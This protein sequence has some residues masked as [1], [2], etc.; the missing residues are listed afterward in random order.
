M[1]DPG[2]TYHNSFLIADPGGAIV[3][4]T[5]GRLGR[6]KPCARGVRSIS[7]G[8]TIPEF[9][10]AHASRV[11]GTI[12]RCDT[13]R[14]ITTHRARPDAAALMSLLRSH[15]SSSW[16]RYSPLS[17]AMGGPCVH[18]GGLLVSAQTTASLVGELR[19]DVQQ[20]W[21]T[22]TAAPCLSLFKPVTVAS[23]LPAVPAP[24]DRADETVAVVAP[25]AAAPRRDARTQPCTVAHLAERDALELEWLADPPDSAAAF[26]EHAARLERWLDAVAVAARPPPTVG[27]ALLGP[28]G[29]RC[30]PDGG[31]MPVDTRCRPAPLRLGIDLDARRH[32]G[33]GRRPAL[34]VLTWC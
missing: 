2:F 13:R 29:P 18:G 26:A 22:A 31:Y 15:G 12:S 32:R 5:A 8:L 33:S 14:S 9:A 4:E 16:P 34:G 6:A 24:T 7:N 11:R 19:P 1:E 25:R 10:A 27:A 21:A 30:R 3:L 20:F 28:P 23:P 17:G